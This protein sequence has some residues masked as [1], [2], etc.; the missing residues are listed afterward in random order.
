MKKILLGVILCLYWALPGLSQEA[1]R[2]Q[3]SVE[4]G[5]GKVTIEYGIPKLGDRKIEDLIKP[6]L[7]W[8]MGRN[9][10]TTLETTIALDFSGKVLK[11]GKYALFARSNQ[12]GE[13]ALLVSTALKMTLEPDSIV[14]EAPLRLVKDDNSQDLLKIGLRSESGGVNILVAW[15]T[16][17]LQG[18]FK[19][20]A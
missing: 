9:Q 18:T 4:I 5:N 1:D 13:W 16:Y 12:N 11:P 3:T 19:P 7:A 17:R 6:G 10:S 15:G 8:R 2:S 14:L 20:A